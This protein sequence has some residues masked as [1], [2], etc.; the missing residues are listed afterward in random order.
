[1]LIRPNILGMQDALG[2]RRDRSLL[3]TMLASLVCKARDVNL[4]HAANTR[5]V[6]EQSVDDLGQIYCSQHDNANRYIDGGAET[7][8]ISSRIVMN[9][10]SAAIIHENRRQA[11]RA[12]G[13]E[14]AVVVEP[15]VA[16]RLICRWQR[17]CQTD[18][19]SVTHGPCVSKLFTRQHMSHALNS[20]ICPQTSKPTTTF[21]PC[22]FYLRPSNFLTNR[23]T[24]RIS[25]LVAF[26][27]KYDRANKNGGQSKS[28]DPFCWSVDTKGKSIRAQPPGISSPN[29]PS[30]LPHLS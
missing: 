21:S 29:L 6:P 7:F 22:H 10:T 25:S 26:R 12:S 27:Y 3:P 14:V 4:L 8:E 24:R 5:Q 28:S 9:R 30:L 20:D 15:Q 2:Q 19:Y 18:G 11:S 13:R 1:M 23:V 16:R 17:T